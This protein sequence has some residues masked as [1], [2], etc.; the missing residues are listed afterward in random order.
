MG[1]DPADSERILW[2]IA[3]H[4][5]YAASEDTDF[6]I[7]LEADFLVNAYEDNLAREACQTADE[8]LFRTHT[9][10]ALLQ[11]LYLAPPYQP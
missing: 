6:R 4:H 2:L 8:R 1:A 7:L 3:H 5:T 9:G 11:A 10:R